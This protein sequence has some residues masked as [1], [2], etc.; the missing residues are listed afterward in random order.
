[1]RKERD[2]A[3]AEAIAATDAIGTNK[4]QAAS[5]SLEAQLLTLTLTP[6]AEPNYGLRPNCSGND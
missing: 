1:M 4:D 6:D 5:S 2:T 3:L